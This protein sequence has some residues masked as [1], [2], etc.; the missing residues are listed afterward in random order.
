MNNS[1]I[2]I[3]KQYIID[4]PD[5]P[6]NIYALATEY[7]EEEPLTA[8]NYYE[9]L[10]EKHP[11][12]LGTYYQLGKLYFSIGLKEK[13]KMT[14]EK[15]IDLAIIKQNSKTLNELRSALNELLDEELY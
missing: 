5:E 7:A 4:E 3:L 10:L 2:V 9:L 15:G 14:F 1:R 12:Y 11:S 8:L 6:F 13:A